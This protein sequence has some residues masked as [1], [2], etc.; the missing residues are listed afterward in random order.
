[1]SAAAPEFSRRVALARLGHDPFRQRITASPEEC[2]RLAR[3]FGLVALDRLT[4]TVALSRR[5]GTAVLLEAAIE[6]DF[7]QECVVSLEPV[8]GSLKQPFALLYGPT[9]AESE[10]AL[11][12]EG[13][14]FEPLLG[15]TIDI[16]EAVAQELSLTLPEFPRDPQAAIETDA[17][18]SEGEKPFAALARWKKAD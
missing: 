9:T 14:D 8:R 7:V 18:A 6:A 15:E 17:A 1:M 5:D 10:V 11:A 4:A 3:R 2:A 13:I 12:G 16:G